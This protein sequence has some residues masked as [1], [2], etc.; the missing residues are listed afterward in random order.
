MKA[1]AIQGYR[2]A[3]IS[4]AALVAVALSSCATNYYTYSG[5]GM[6]IGQGGASTMVNGVELW[7]TGTPPRKYQIIG[8]IED[9][10]PGGPIPMAARNSQV[11]AKA[12][13]Q[14]GDGVILNSDLAEH[15]GT[16]SNG[17]AFAWS[18]GYYGGAS[19]FGTSVP[20]IKRTGRYYVVKYVD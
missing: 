14:G 6:M 15:I 16:I 10:R 11:A 12:R 1:Y 20:I 13:A 7:V 9:T 17:N 4:I 3:A 8:Y 19:A 2:N 18:N 5:S